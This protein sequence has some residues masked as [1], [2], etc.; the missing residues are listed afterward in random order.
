MAKCNVCIG[1]MLEVSGCNHH[2]YLL[3]D[4]TEVAPVK[5]G[6]PG[7]WLFGQEVERCMDCNAAIGETHHIGCDTERCKLCRGQFISCGCDY[8]NQ[9]IV[10]NK[11]KTRGLS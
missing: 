4:G 2:I 5:A 7:D 6:E 1:E 11:N 9:I 10:I 8:S 3:N